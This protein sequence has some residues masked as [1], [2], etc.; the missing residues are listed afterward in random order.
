MRQNQLCCASLLIANFLALVAVAGPP[1]DVLL[2]AT[3]KGYVSVAQAEAARDQF[4]E[5]QFGQLLDDDV[6]SDFVKSLEQQLK[7]KFGDVTNRLGFVYDDLDGVP[8]GELSLAVIERPGHDAS[9]AIT[10]DVTGRDAA[11]KDFLAA[12]E[13]RLTSEGGVKR[14]VDAA[15][16]KLTIYDIPAKNGI[17]DLIQTVYFV[18][19]NVLVGINGREE[20]EAMLKRFAG[21]PKDNL[22]SLASYAATMAKLDKSSQGVK[23]EV[24]F[25]ADPFG[26]TYAVRTLDKSVRLREDKDLAKILA[27]QGFDAIKGIGG[28][29][30]MLAEG[31]SDYVYRVA[32][33][34]PPVAGKETDPLRWNLAMQ[35]LQLPN[36]PELIPQSW[37]PRMCARYATY[38]VEVLNAFDHF[39][40]LF[41]AIEGHKD[42]FKTSMEG[43]EQDAYGPQVNVRD[44]LVAH[45]NDR[46][47]LITDYSV[48]ISIHSERSLIAIEAKDEKELANT[49][50]RIMEKEPD[51]ER[52]EFE[53]FVIW[54]RVPEDTGV[55]ELDIDAPSLSPL[56]I[57]APKPAA[58]GD[59]EKERVLPNSA[60]CVAFGQLMLASDIKYLEYLL[61]GFGQREL[62]T[63]S[64][65]YQLVAARMAKLAPG[66]RSGWSFVRTDEAFRPTYELIRQGRMPESETMFGK[67]LNRLL[68][69]EVE[70][71][72]GIL[73]KQRLD[74]SELPNFETVRRYF[75]PAGRVLRSDPDGW[76]L[77]GT[78]LNKEA[79]ARI[80]ERGK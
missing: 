65:D 42:A 24:R 6:M 17:D 66:P 3:T 20:A 19:D 14:E 68:T 61:G 63:S 69:T 72:E 32:V 39:G 15:G 22:H 26:L 56:Q 44:E 49:I 8:A 57:E 80:A 52:R 78:V 55:Q 30:N 10:I 31:S 70:K 23:P 4:K 12:V 48:P 21:A 71:E 29:A 51:V 45:L 43:I 53:N 16:T 46:I 79:P 7:D 67:F 18:H 27:E 13:K 73:R 34:A 2:P 35:M 38:N 74:G 75:G 9:L 28:Y 58:D 5:T 1:S 59:Q 40:T 25:F 37:A 62:L 60:V 11:V 54:E 50:R 47:T 77:T 33:Y 36:T 76:L 41:D 64:G